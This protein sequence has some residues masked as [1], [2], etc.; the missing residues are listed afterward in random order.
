VGIVLAPPLRS[1]HFEKKAFKIAYFALSFL[2]SSLR[3]DM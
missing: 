3:Q 1:A 2:A